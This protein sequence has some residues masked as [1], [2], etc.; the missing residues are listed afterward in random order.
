[1]DPLATAG[2][3]RRPPFSLWGNFFFLFFSVSTSNPAPRDGFFFGRWGPADPPPPRTEFF[4]RVSSFF[5]VLERGEVSLD[6]QPVTEF[7]SNSSLNF[8]LYLVRK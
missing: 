4:Y 7:R 6:P 2:G 5:S 1:M 3:P 8:F